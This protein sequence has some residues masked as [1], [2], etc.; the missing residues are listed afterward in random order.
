MG[1]ISTLEMVRP[2]RVIAAEAVRTGSGEDVV[3]G[4]IYAGTPF[5]SEKTS[6]N[7]PRQRQLTGTCRGVKVGRAGAGLGKALGQWRS[8]RCFSTIGT[9]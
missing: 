1:G 5:L 8:A 4:F 6:P 3:V 2:L 9:S 7:P